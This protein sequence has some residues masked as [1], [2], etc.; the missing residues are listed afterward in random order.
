MAEDFASEDLAAEEALAA[1][2][3]EL[4]LVAAAGSVAAPSASLS[5]AS[6]PGR[7]MATSRRR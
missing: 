2:P 6:S 5:G 1:D 3:A 7:Y 4:E